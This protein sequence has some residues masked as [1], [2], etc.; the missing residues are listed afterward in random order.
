MQTGKIYEFGHFQFDAAE[1]LLFRDGRA[2]ALP[3]KAAN[4]LSIL[5]EH[6][7]HLVE[8]ED[9]MRS[10]WPDVCVEEANLPVTIS[11]LR[12]TLGDKENSIHYIDTVP[13]RGYRFVGEV[14][15]HV[16]P[17][18]SAESAS[19]S[20]LAA[21]RGHWMTRGVQELAAAVAR[22]P[23]SL[24]HSR[25]AETPWK[26]ILIAIGATSVVTLVG[27]MTL[28]LRLTPALSEADPVLI[29]DFVNTTG[30]PVFDDTLKQAIS[31]QLSQSPFFN[32]LSDAKAR[33]TLK[34]M[35][36][37]AETRLTPD[38]ARELCQR[39]GSKA[40]IAGSIASLG[41]QYVIGL[42]AI[43]CRTGDSLAQ[44]QV[45]ASSK[46][47]VFTALDKAVTKLRGKV[48]ESLSSVEK[49]DTPL[50]DATTP[51]LEALKAFSLGMLKER[52]NDAEAI[53]FLKRAIEL[54]PNF[55]SAYEGLGATYYNMGEAGLAQEN[56]TKAFE[57]RE[58]VSEREKFTIAARYYNYV[59]GELEKAVEIYQLWAQAYPHDA[60]ARVGLG[61]L[62][63][64]TGQFQK[65][66]DH[67]LEGLR[68][69]P[70]GGANY[71]NLVLSY[72]ALDRFDEAKAIHQ[73][74]MARG[75]DDPL[76]RVN[77]FGVAFVQG[78][79]AEMDRQMA[80]S[81]GKPEGE[82]TFLAA[83]S[84]AEAFYGHVGEAREFSQRAVD[85]ALRSNQKETAAQWRMDEAV[86]EAEF[87][88]REFAR[89]T[90]AA[91]LALS[92][93]H[94]TQI[95]AALA[96]ARTGD[97]ARAEAMAKD[98]SKGYPLDTL[99]NRY[100]LPV[101]QASVE[102]DR[103][104][105][106]K[107]IQILEATSPYEF[108]SPQTWSGLGGPLYP[109]YLRG[110]SYLQLRQ[111]REAT[112]EFHKILDHPGFML[113]C[114]LRPLAYLELARAYVLLG[115]AQ[116]TRTNYQEFLRLWKDADP[117]VPILREAKSEYSS[118]K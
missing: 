69:E 17:G 3:P 102:L 65:A 15:V 72:A 99:V 106:A 105:P 54:D 21:S 49:F 89:R 16:A 37:P 108:A 7:G 85:S 71:S 111:G 93:N 11:L 78:D 1:R 26:W 113:A 87:G 31:V 110:Q 45:T 117:E 104:N 20:G 38:V 46:E 59:T 81:A 6:R 29:S 47:K 62:Y 64:A 30:D 74:E 2:V 96:L 90:T 98:L 94:D 55:A 112:A 80:W 25:L 50:E 82:D 24:S 19:A 101:I 95:L 77:W 92:A 44:E 27:L 5:I 35:D 67:T 14:R 79:T 10:V 66:I 115:N 86:R 51:S 60:A 43:N 56:F 76:A 33:S 114:A 58:R 28:P 22:S 18:T 52:V 103:N 53:P 68:L 97:T 9:L 109:A 73:Q 70:E 41:S 36:K 34:L 23:R 63:G 107:A 75:I 91:A 32:I 100:W 42:K 8:K 39:A 12:K 84:D 4:T 61:S 88:N 57:L 83:K 40:Y 118:L 13:R 116:E 48:G